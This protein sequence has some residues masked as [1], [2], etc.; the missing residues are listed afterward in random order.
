MPVME[1]YKKYLGEKIAENLPMSA[2]EFPIVI[3]RGDTL[4]ARGAINKLEDD[5]L[6]LTGNIK[7]GDKVQFACGYK[8]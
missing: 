6:L 5:S 2:L 1:V 4:A 7:V 3:H 8:Q